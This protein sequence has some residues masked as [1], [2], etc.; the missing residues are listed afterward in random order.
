MVTTLLQLT[1]KDILQRPL[2]QKAE[3]V[4]SV[5]AL[6]RTVRWVHIMEVTQ[7][8]HLLN[9]NE[10][11]L[12]TGIGWHD[13]E[14]ISIS[15]LQQLIDC[16]ASGL[17]IELGTYMK[18]P[19]DRMRELALRANFPLIFF[20]EEV[21]YI[22]ITQDLHAY[23]IHQHH[24]M[25]SELESLSTHLN[26]LLLSGKGLLPLLKL[27]H[28][29]TQAQ[30]AFF[31]LGAEAQFVPP[32]PKHKAD[33]FYEKWI[34]GEMFDNPEVKS[35][36]AHRPILALEHLFADLLI[37]A[38]QELSEFQVLAL[39]R[40]ATA[41]AQEM[42]RTKYIEE[43]RRYKEDLWVIDWLNGKHSLQEIRDYIYS[44]K[45]TAKLNRLIVCVFDAQ[46]HA[47][48]YKDWEANLIQKNMVARAI[49]EGE[50]FYLLP[51]MRQEQIVFILLDQLPAASAKERILRAVR[52]LQK[53]E[54]HQ[55]FPLFSSL[56]GVGKELSDPTLAKD[57]YETAKETILIQKDTGALAEPF[58]HELHVYKVIINLKKT[59][60]LQSF[61][62]EYIGPV[63]SYDREK[64]SHLLKTLKV[65]LA[66]CGSKQDT[67]KELFI[68][69]QTLYHRLDKIAALL[70]DDY[71][72]PSKRIAIELAL[73][74][75]E[76]MNG[77]IH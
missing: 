75:Y 61:I 42:M 69:R 49:F 51:T 23:F 77:A 7:V 24:K 39:D 76:Y 67:A 55:E 5:A 4:A 37:H 16:G 70:G 33:T 56:Y 17:C 73:H 15:F 41:I 26:Q 68:V 14:E 12:S 2:F 48:Q 28:Q 47:E 46:A 35:T 31:P 38:D 30:V 64:S 60:L 53:T 13:D 32:L 8:G 59:G 66:L 9:G 44:M 54:I 57:S 72:D 45:P 3:A 25:V 52:R 1:V 43:K 58:Y 62:D 40:F 34:Y 11:I 50:G 36:L 19:M 71:M 63:V 74:G 20:H 18:K 27:L 29:T 10:L 65:Y 6:N 22:D 21:R